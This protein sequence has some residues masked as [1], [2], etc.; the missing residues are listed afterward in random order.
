MLLRLSLRNKYK[1]ELKT[2]KF[3]SGRIRKN[4][5]MKKEPEK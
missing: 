3:I 4:Y 5:R 2:K 1:N